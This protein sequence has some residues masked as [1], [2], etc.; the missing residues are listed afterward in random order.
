MVFLLLA[1]GGVFKSAPSSSIPER[2]VI[3]A[4]IVEDP[5]PHKNKPVSDQKKRNTVSDTAAVIIV[6]QAKEVEVDSGNTVAENPSNT[7]IR[8]SYEI[9]P[10]SGSDNIIEAIT[11]TDEKMT[12]ERSTPSIYGKD[13]VSVIRDSIEKVKMYPL[14]ARK[15]GIE[16]KVIIRFRIRTDGRVEEIHIFKNSG[17]EILD[18]IA[19]ET[20]KRA[21]PLP[22]VNGWIEM[23]LIFRLD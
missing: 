17:H 7:S 1:G 14:L 21:A 4:E 2:A 13:P 20:I 8:D 15:K 18:R 10:Y 6:V 16:G 23:P 5:E 12:V 9:K 11:I 22:Y 3:T 19:I